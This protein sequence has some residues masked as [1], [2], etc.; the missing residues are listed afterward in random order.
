M[1]NND[2]RL[3]VVAAHNI[4]KY[5][6]ESHRSRTDE[7]RNEVQRKSEGGREKREANRLKLNDQCS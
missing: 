2:R 6:F 4:D 7:K 3:C 1:Q 5:H